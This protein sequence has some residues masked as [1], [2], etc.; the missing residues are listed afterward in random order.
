MQEEITRRDWF[1]GLAMVAVIRSDEW[2]L[3]EAD[4]QEE[5]AKTAYDIADAM[6]QAR[7]DTE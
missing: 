1:A 7:E 4:T 6:V 5:I 2:R 3:N